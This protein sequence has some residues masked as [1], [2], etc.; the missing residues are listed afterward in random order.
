LTT[1]FFQ[2][3]RRPLTW[4]VDTKNKVGIS[5]TKE[6]QCKCPEL[7]SAT[8]ATGVDGKWGWPQHFETID[9]SSPITNRVLLEA[10]LFHQYNHWGW[11]PVPGQGPDM[12]AFT[13]QSTSVI[14]RGYGGPDADHWQKDWRYRAAVSYVTGA[15]AL[16]VGVEGALRTADLVTFWRATNC[17]VSSLTGSESDDLG[18]RHTVTCG[19]GC[20]DRDRMHDMDVEGSDAL[21]RAAIRP[22]KT[23]YPA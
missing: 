21:R 16:K 22:M 13:E 2:R 4:Q 6:H 20:I 5:F 14:Y 3:R 8:R 18:R 15:S 10:G 17:N 19:A 23:Y 9:W 7:V 1:P 11:F 12:I